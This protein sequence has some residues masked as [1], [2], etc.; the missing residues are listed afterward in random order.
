MVL[1][2]GSPPPAENDNGAFGNQQPGS[3]GNVMPTPPPLVADQLPRALMMVIADSP[4]FFG[5]PQ[6]APVMS[7]VI[8]DA[9]FEKVQARTSVEA[10]QSRLDSK[11]AELSDLKEKHARLEERL[12]AAAI[13]GT[14]QKICTFVG[15]AAVGFAIEFYKS[16]YT[17]VSILLG[18]FG[19]ALLSTNLKR[20][21]KS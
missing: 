6:I 14:M 2:V 18:L 13:L 4:E 16:N 7:A 1:I 9:R 17:N 15:T 3:A 11:N 5:G 20:G 8:S 12:E 21:K 10:I 19:L